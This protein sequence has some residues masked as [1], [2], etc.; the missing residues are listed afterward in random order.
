MLHLVRAT[1]AAC[2]LALALLVIAGC[3]ESKAPPQGAPADAPPAPDIDQGKESQPPETK[4]AAADGDWATLSGRIV[5]DGKPPVPKPIDTTKDPT[6]KEKLTTENILVSP[7]GGLANAVIMLRT[8]K[9]PVHPDYKAAKG[10]VALDN[11]N[12]RFEPHVQVVQLAQQLMIK[13]SDPTGH[14]TNVAPIQPR[15]TAFNQMLAQSAQPIPYKF[16]AEEGVP[17]PVK[18]NIHPWMSAWLVVREDPY[19]AVTDKDGRFTI[20]NLPAG[21]E[22]EFRLWQ[23]AAGYLK[24]ATFKGGK[25][26]A[27]GT[28]KFKLKPGDND[29]G[30]IKV[31]GSIFKQ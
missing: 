7:D 10:E 4:T 11:K 14:N 5:F 19:A 23:E 16:A 18:C 6:C 12:C 27:R 25:T 1:Y 2:F 3:G 26:D 28:F 31:S 30:D 15:N 9:V 24:N 8:K 17:I 21:K 29:L 20:K 13:N 22:L